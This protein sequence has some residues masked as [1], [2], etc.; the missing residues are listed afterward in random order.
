MKRIFATIFAAV[1]VMFAST[2]VASATVLTEA[3]QSELSSQS[4]SAVFGPWQTNTRSIH[5]GLSIGLCSD[6]SIDLAGLTDEPG[7]YGVSLNF[8]GNI[9]PVMTAI[10]FQ[11]GQTINNRSYTNVPAIPSL[12]VTLVA[13]KAPIGAYDDSVRAE[14][15]QTVLMTVPTQGCHFQKVSF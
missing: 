4:S 3:E 13:T 6:G 2:G 14:F 12:P 11:P 5:D 8:F 10:E 1:A 9:T 15:S 7:M